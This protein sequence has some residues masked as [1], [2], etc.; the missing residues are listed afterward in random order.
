[1][2][3]TMTRERKLICREMSDANEMAFR[4]LARTLR[5]AGKSEK[6]TAAYHAACLS[7]EDYLRWRGGTADLLA[8]TRDDALGWLIEL[9]RNGG[10][11]ARGGGLVQ[12]GRP[13]AKDSVFSYFGSARRFYNYAAAEG[14]IG[15]SPMAGLEAPPKSGKPVPLP[16]TG[17]LRA[18]IATCSPRGRRRSFADVRDEFMIRLLAETGGPRCSE[19]ALLPAEHLDLRNDV[20]L[21]E[22][23]GGRWRTIPLSATTAQAAQRYMIARRGHKAA[24]LPPVFLGARGPLSANGVYQVVRRRGELAGIPGLHPHAIRHYA[25]DAAKSDEMSDGDIMEL[26]GWST[27]AMLQRYGAAQKQKRAIAAARR[28]R[29]GDRL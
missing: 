2:S 28:H 7:L 13:L 25:A 15:A 4:G 18:V 22:G 23:K 17:A 1:M 27:P 20:A 16:E 21:I 24:H 12:L 29:I 9:Q 10:W 8:V 5:A 11:S 19:V 6:T 14:L 3:A 26:F